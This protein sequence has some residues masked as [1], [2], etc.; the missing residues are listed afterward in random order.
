VAIREFTD[1]RGRRWMVWDVFPTL[2]SAA[3]EMQDHQRE[4]ANDGGSTS[5]ASA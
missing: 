4:C 2:P 5:I 3:T 1:S